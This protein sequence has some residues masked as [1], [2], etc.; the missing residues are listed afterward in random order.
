MSDQKEEIKHRFSDANE[1]VLALRGD[2]QSKW[3]K[4]M[5]ACRK[6]MAEIN[7]PI[8][9]LIA[10]GLVPRI[11]ALASG[12]GGGMDTGHN[13]EMQI[14]AIWCCTNIASGTSEQTTHLI[15]QGA[16]IIVLSL[17]YT[18]PKREYEWQICNQALWCLGNFVG[19]SSKLRDL[20]LRAGIVDAIMDLFVSKTDLASPKTRLDLMRNAA[21]IIS[22]TLRG[23]PKPDTKL[24]APAIPWLAEHLR[25]GFHWQEPA[26]KDVLVALCDFISLADEDVVDQIL[27]CDVCTYSARLIIDIKSS[28]I[29]TANSSSDTSPSPS[30]SANEI[31][32]IALNI[33]GAVV[34]K[35][36]KQT[37]VAVDAGL[38][39]I[40]KLLT[41]EKIEDASM[42]KT[43]MWI[44]SNV[45]CNADHIQII[46]DHGLVDH[47]IHATKDP[48]TR[49][50]LEAAHAVANFTCYGDDGQITF[51]I[52]RGIIPAIC[53][54]LK[55]SNETTV[56]VTLEAVD[57]MF[58]AYRAD[59]PFTSIIKGMVKEGG[60]LRL[61]DV[62]RNH[63]NEQVCKLAAHV[64]R[65]HFAEEEL[66]V[67]L[68]K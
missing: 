7:P 14:D 66:G 52:A 9:D 6:I 67:V 54:M 28:L 45:A 53:E 48:S 25:S 15:D 40:I 64:L 51:S 5:R 63:R 12:A 61:L 49:I 34:S 13:H 21:W 57:N 1:M 44:I 30:H 43:I 31:I 18:K 60:G 39:D 22:L 42:K 10:S 47:I 35:T 23:E 33:L 20:L 16:H 59:L 65:S 55:S 41:N 36:D 56:T 68:T 50:Q 19:D 3:P 27:K 2:D 62:L 46:I 38:F 24:I 29:V 58:K 11:V 26:L 4:A 32:N 8:D 37:K 17:L